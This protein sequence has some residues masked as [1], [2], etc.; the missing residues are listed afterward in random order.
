MNRRDL[1]KAVAAVPVAAVAAPLAI[2]EPFDTAT[3]QVKMRYT[4]GDG[5]AL[6][7]RAHPVSMEGDFDVAN[8]HYDPGELSP[9]SLE[10]VQLEVPE[11]EF[12]Y[13]DLCVHCRVPAILVE[14][15]RA[16]FACWTRLA[17]QRAEALAYSMNQTW[18]EALQRMPWPW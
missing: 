2:A 3:M 8:L 14:D 18:H 4:H 15:G 5:V 6:C 10:T 12:G 7:S 1:L 9:D 11:H 16:E 17:L 13:N